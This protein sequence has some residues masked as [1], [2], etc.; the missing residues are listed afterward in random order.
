MRARPPCTRRPS[1]PTIG[2]EHDTRRQS[3]RTVAATRK[4]GD[5]MQQRTRAC[6]PLGMAAVALLHLAACSDALVQDLNPGGQ[7]AGD[8]TTGGGT[9][10]GS[11]PGG[12]NPGNGN[13][14]MGGDGTSGDDPTDPNQAMDPNQGG[15]DPNAG[16]QGP[17]VRPMVL[18]QHN[19]PKRTGANL[20]EKALNV[21]TVASSRFQR[22][23]TFPVDGDVYAQ[24][25]YMTQAS[26]NGGQHNVLIV[27]TAHNSVY[28]FDADAG[29]S[30]APLWQSNAGRPIP[31]SDFPGETN[32]QTEIG[33]TGTPVI[34]PTSKSIYFVAARKLLDSGDANAMYG[35]YLHRLRLA[36]GTEMPGSPVAVEAQAPGTG[37]G[38]NNNVVRLVHQTNLQRTGLLLAN[39]QVYFGLSAHGITTAYHG[40]LLAYDAETLTPSGTFVS[41]PNSAA[42]GVWQGGQ[43]PAVDDAG[44]VYATTSNS[45]GGDATQER[46]ESLVKFQQQGSSMQVVDY[47]TPSN[48]ATLDA[49]DQDFG[50]TGVVLVPGR[51]LSVNGDKAGNLYFA[52]TSALGGL[53]ADDSALAQKVNMGGNT[54]F[55]AA[56]VFYAAPAGGRVYAWAQ[57]DTLHAWDVQ[58]ASVPAVPVDSGPSSLGT[59]YMPGGMLSLSADGKAPQSAVLWATVS[60]GGSSSGTVRQGVLYAFDASNLNQ[61]LYSSETNHARDGLGTLAKFNPPTVAAGKVYVGTFSGGVAVYGLQ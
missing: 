47:F 45:S 22:L 24:P 27:A 16:T 1:D 18:T 52:K 28:A 38:A 37:F 6:W 49:L 20:L 36:D 55:F 53:G 30:A 35:H 15:T 5:T 3:R 12:N 39:G 31:I 44:F 34:D 26:V 13:V 2:A 59:I 51:A 17:T 7:P 8:P 21:Q 56:P 60:L 43:G 58:S 61:L 4:A 23:D 19:D 57:N 46:I 10:D 42:S 48:W 54:A 33:I 50:S 14:L 25:L 32:F 9:P 40:W 29:G 41:S 11:I